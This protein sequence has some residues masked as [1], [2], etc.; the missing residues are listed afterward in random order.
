[1]LVIAC[2]FHS[3]QDRDLFLGEF[4]KLAKYVV[5]CEPDT[6]AYETAIADTGNPLKVL[7]YERSA[8]LGHAI[9][10]RTS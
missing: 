3:E 9:C 8:S 7:I 6:L 10:H 2:E 1:M 5:Q 4:E